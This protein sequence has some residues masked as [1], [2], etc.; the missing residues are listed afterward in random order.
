MQAPLPIARRSPP[1]FQEAI[2]QLLEA[3]VTGP[4]GLLSDRLHM[5]AECRIA[6]VIPRRLF[7]VASDAIARSL[8]QRARRRRIEAGVVTRRKVELPPGATGFVTIIVNECARQ[9][10]G[11]GGRGATLSAQRSR[12]ITSGFI[13]PR[14][15]Q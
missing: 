7:R 6:P 3:I 13:H 15:T 5:R 11:D 12:Y 9:E 1:S 14:K 8:E 2:R 10:G 4:R